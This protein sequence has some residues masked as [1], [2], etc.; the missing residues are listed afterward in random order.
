M[1]HLLI[2]YHNSFIRG[3]DV[4]YFYTMFELT[5]TQLQERG[6]TIPTQFPRLQEFYQRHGGYGLPE[7]LLIREQ[8]DKITP[9]RVEMTDLF[10][11]MVHMEMCSVA[12]RKIIEGT[13]R[14]SVVDVRPDTDHVSAEDLYQIVDLIPEYHDCPHDEAMERY[15]Q[16]RKQHLPVPVSAMERMRRMG[17]SEKYIDRL[18]AGKLTSLDEA[19][20]HAS[21]SVEENQ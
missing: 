18:K 8:I 12:D 2:V 11:E 3:V 14:G 5:Q 20:L 6:S 7:G 13:L 19:I 21:L 10:A 15:T 17:G 16:I 1:F 9:V 4:E